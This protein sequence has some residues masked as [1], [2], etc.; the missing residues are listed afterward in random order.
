[1][2]EEEEVASDDSSMQEE[3]RDEGQREDGLVIHQ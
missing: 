1:M 2:S 3:L